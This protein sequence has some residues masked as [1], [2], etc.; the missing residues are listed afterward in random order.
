[1]KKQEILN[2]L[3][4]IYNTIAGGKKYPLAVI[5]GLWRIILDI[6][7]ND[8]AEFIQSELFEILKDSFNI[9]SHGIGYILDLK[10]N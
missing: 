2:K 4:N 9:K 7:V 5:N 3:C 6:K 8:K 10:N 1:M